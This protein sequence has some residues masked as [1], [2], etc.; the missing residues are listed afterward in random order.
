MASRI[1]AIST[2]LIDTI[3]DTT[4]DEREHHR[5]LAQ[6]RSARAYWV[7]LA[8]KDRAYSFSALMPYFESL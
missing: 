6:E 2:I 8:F 7:G 3:I 5:E 4:W 1:L